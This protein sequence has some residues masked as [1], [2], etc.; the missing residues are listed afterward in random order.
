M[1]LSAEQVAALTHDI[2]WL[3]DAVVNGEHVLV[4]VLCQAQAQ[5]QADGRLAPNGALIAGHDL[6]LISGGDLANQGTLRA[7]GDLSATA[8]TSIPAA[9]P[10][11]TCSE[12]P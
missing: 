4:P 1:G 5:A 12:F 7:S 11:L 10:S 2:V 6:T 9:C 3:E 8:A